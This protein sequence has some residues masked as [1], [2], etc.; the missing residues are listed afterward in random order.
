MSMPPNC[1]CSRTWFSSPSSPLQY[2]RMQIFPWVRSSTSWA[3][4]FAASEV[5]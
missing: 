3:K 4:Y 2:S 1:T 5:G